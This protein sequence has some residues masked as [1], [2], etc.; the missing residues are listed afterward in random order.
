MATYPNRSTVDGS[1][2]TPLDDAHSTGSVP[3]DERF[4]VTVRVRRKAP[5]QGMTAEGL[6]GD[7]L[8]SKRGYLSHD[9]YVTKHG[10]E[11]ADLAK[12]EAFAHAHHLIVVESSAARRSVFLSGTAAAFAKAFGTTIEHFEYDGGSY[13]GRTG[14][15]TVPSDLTDIIGGYSGSTTGP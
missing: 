3:E 15:L 12:I 13:R 8:P 11:P 4:E 5:L 6:H 1:N 10:A 7:Q 14:S 9:A 2:R